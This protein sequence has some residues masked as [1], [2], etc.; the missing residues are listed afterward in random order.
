MKARAIFIQMVGLMFVF[1]SQSTYADE[2]GNDD[3]RTDEQQ[4][5]K[6]QENIVAQLAKQVR[7][8]PPAQGRPVPVLRIVAGATRG[9]RKLPT[10]TLMA[11]EHVAYTTQSRPTLY[12]HL[13]ETTAR[14]IILSLMADQAQVPTMEVGLDG[15]KGEGMHA[16]RLSDHGFELETGKTYIWSVTV[17]ASDNPAVRSRI[18]RVTKA[19]IGRIS[20]EPSIV[21]EINT[22]RDPR[23]QAF[24][25]GRH[26]IW[27][28]ALMRYKEAESNDPSH[29]NQEN[30][31][32]LVHQIGLND[33]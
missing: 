23:S 26:G 7:Y 30:R 28:D 21:S 22:T 8:I 27:Y 19:Y 31:D 5:P 13:S 1:L 33:N 32:M 10:V 16:W 6:T 18:G 4:A 15:I 25:Y 29:L 17:S 20:A 14:P 12:W 11:P 2:R 24:V 9:P 3:I